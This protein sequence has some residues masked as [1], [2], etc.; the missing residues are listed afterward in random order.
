MTNSNS[1]AS[2]S[3][4]ML[5]GLIA[6]LWI[7]ET[8]DKEGNNKSLEHITEDMQAKDAP[9]IGEEENGSIHT[10]TTAMPDSGW[11]SD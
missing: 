3:F 2:L 9:P 1:K 10:Q 5:M 11:R 6:T 7:P 8:R 4:F